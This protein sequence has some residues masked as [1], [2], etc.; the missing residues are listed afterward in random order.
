[1]AWISRNNPYVLEGRQDRVELAAALDSTLWD[2]PWYSYLPNLDR[3]VD[4]DGGAFSFQTDS[5]GFRTEPVRI[6]KPEGTYRIVCVGGSTTV[7]GMSNQRTYPSLLQAKLRE[8]FGR[9]KIEVVNCGISG[10]SS[11]GES[12]KAAEY[13]AY[14]PDLILEYNC[15]NDLWIWADAA[16][17]R[18]P[19]GRSLLAESRWVRDTW[20]ASLTR[21]G[22]NRYWDRAP[23]LR[24]LGRLARR[25][26]AADAEIA[27]VSFLRPRF[28]DL[29]AAE[30]DFYLYDLTYGWKGQLLNLETYSLWIDT[31]N[32]RLAEW[33]DRQ[34]LP[35]FDLAA[36]MT[37][38]AETFSD[39][40]H[41]TSDGIERKA[42]RLARLLTPFLES[43]IS[44]SSD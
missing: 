36:E 25:A 27:F 41:L 3:R 8:H 39:V 44:S 20:S 21:S 12:R 15:V 23:I 18:L 43:R 35:F 10:I 30:R 6:P 31:Y 14:E 9:D 22:F 11:D 5:L 34:S 26:H 42:K 37:G 24:R 28:E 40:C 32:L 29:S 19:A 16:Y 38:G 17:R 33:C 4:F 2:V 1:M 13:L 7:E